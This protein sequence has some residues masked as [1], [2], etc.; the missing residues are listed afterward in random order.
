MLRDLLKVNPLDQK[1]TGTPGMAA[2]N[3]GKIYQS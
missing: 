1:Q 2:Y 3:Q